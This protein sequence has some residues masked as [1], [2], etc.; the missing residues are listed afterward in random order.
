[1][2]IYSDKFMSFFLSALRFVPRMPHANERRGV[3]ILAAAC[4]C[5]LSTS[6]IQTIRYS[7]TFTKRKDR[8]IETADVT[9]VKKLEKL[10]TWI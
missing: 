1:M 10:S 3:R 5:F 4:P 9:I 8:E 2:H 6:L 7:D